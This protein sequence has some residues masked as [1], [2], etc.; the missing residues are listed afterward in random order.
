MTIRHWRATCIQ[1][2]NHVVNHVATREEAMAIV[3]RSLDRWISFIGPISRGTSKDIRNLVLFPEFALTGFPVLETAEEWIE[4]ACIRIPG[5]ETQRLQEAARKFGVFIGANAYEFD[6]QWPGR[7]FNCCFL[8]DPSGEVILKYKRVNTVHSPSPHDFMDRY[9]EHYGVEGAFPVV[10]TELGNI[11]MFPCGEIMYPEAARVL[12][13]RGAEVILH[14]TSDHGPS[15]TIGWEQCKRARAAENMVYLVSCNS[16]G[17]TGPLPNN[18]NMGHSKIIDYNGNIL[19]NSG[20]AGES[21]VASAMIDV[22]GLRVLRQEVGPLNRIARQRTEM[23]MRVYN[24]ASFYPPNRFVE[25]TMG[26]KAEI[27]QIMR[28]TMER[29]SARGVV[30]KP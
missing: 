16:G 14:P 17:M 15:S 22:Q 1:T 12:M 18:N 10:K 30:T 24:D 26:S 2:I 19:A 7:Y 13:M 21:T 27:S 28:E 5:P 11:G 6:P 4:K 25:K 8:I 3:H 20:G 9:F 23:Y 29:L